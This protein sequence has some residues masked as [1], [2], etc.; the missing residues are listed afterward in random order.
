MPGV[1]D[2][3]RRRVR[4]EDLHGA[5]T[6]ADLHRAAGIDERDDI[7][8]PL[9]MNRAVL[10]HRGGADQVERLGQERRQGPQPRP[11][12]RPG[13]GDGAPGGRADATGLVGLEHRI[14]P[15]LQV[16][17][18]VEGPR[19]HRQPLPDPDPAL[20][21]ALLL[22]AADLAGVDM[23]AHRTGVDAVLLVDRAP[24]AAPPRD[25]GL[26]VVDPVDGRDAAEPAVGLVVDAM[27]GELVGGAAP[28]DGVLAAVAEDHDEGVDRRRPLRVT[29]IDAAELAP[30]A[31]GLGPRRGLDPAE[32]SE[33]RP[34]E[35]GADE[36]ADGL[37]GAA[38]AVLL[39]EVVVEQL[40]AGRPAL[41]KGLGLSVPPVRDDLG[42]A[43]LLDLERLVPTV[44]GPLTGAT[45]VVAD[46][47]LGDAQHAGGLSGGLASLVQDL[48]RHDLLPRELGQG[49]ASERG[50]G[51]GP[52]R[53]ASGTSADLS[54]EIRCD[55]R[56]GPPQARTN[57][58]L[59]TPSL[60]GSVK[61]WRLIA[62]MIGWTRVI[63]PLVL[64]SGTACRR[65]G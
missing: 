55:Q 38:V 13:L 63:R 47:A 36:L 1:R 49:A 35:A 30:V 32:R 59:L 10:V 16:I 20:G 58:G 60:T 18:A 41:A 28:D 29:Q 15:S 31:L 40:D 26:E 34:A 22:G 45:E 9:E 56:T 27:P 64:A 61:L 53:P 7:A 17:Q 62:K 52:S 39:A 4:V 43:G 3:H 6:A 50:Q 11:L 37:V 57:S 54:T 42:Q 33:P 8:A 14:G 48:D 2:E 21:L 44:V 51:C 12:G 25:A 23:E 65:A 19:P 5:G 24:G 46:S